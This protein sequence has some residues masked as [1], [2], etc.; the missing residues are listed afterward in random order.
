[1]QSISFRRAV[2][3]DLPEIVQMLADDPLGA[4]RESVGDSTR[5]RVPRAF[6][7]IDADPNQLLAVATIGEEIVG[8]LQLTFLPGLSRKG[9][10]RGQIKGVRISQLAARPRTGQAALRLGHRRMPGAWLPLRAAHD[11][12]K[13][14]GRAPFLR[15]AGVSSAATSATSWPY[16]SRQAPLDQPRLSA[17]QAPPLGHPVHPGPLTNRPG[18]HRWARHP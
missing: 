18:S 4:R 9:A 7:A 8:T 10:W 6:D 5:W 16:S 2:A 1:M 15:A 12:L 13:P 11:R 17:L 3:A 14:H